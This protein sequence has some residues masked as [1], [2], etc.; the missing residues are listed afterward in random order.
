MTSLVVA[1]QYEDAAKNY[2]K[3]LGITMSSG[4][5]FLG[6]VIG[7]LEYCKYFM[8]QKVDQWVEFVNKVS[9]AAVKAPQRG[10]SFLKRLAANLAHKWEKT[11]SQTCGYIKALLAFAI[12]QFVFEVL[13]VEVEKW[14]WV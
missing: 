5:R 10:R 2:F 1:P 14:T 8:N 7:T 13:T 6:G 12:I 3:D 11:Y 9:K 4:H